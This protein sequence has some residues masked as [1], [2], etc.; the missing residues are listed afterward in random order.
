MPKILL[1]EDSD[2]IARIIVHKLEK[3]NYSIFRLSTGEKVYET[4]LSLNPDLLILDLLLPIRNGITIL[5]D[6]KSNPVTT[7]IPVIIFTTNNNEEML[8]SAIKLGAVDY[9]LRPFS[10]S[11]LTAKVKKHTNF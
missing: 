10:T 3:E 7:N 6:L 8:Q 4:A 9:I 11:E 5:R 2:I 1:A